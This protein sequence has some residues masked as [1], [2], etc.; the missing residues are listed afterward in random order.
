M[1]KVSSGKQE[2]N[3]IVVAHY[4]VNR[5]RQNKEV[6]KFLVLTLYTTYSGYRIKIMASFNGTKDVYFVVFFLDYLTGAGALPQAL[7]TEVCVCWLS[8]LISD[9]LKLVISRSVLVRWF[10]S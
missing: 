9:S 7:I 3:W 10:S 8:D 2:Q 4:F 6:K 5:S 1:P